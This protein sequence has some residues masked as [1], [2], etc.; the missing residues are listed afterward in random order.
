MSAP[1]QPIIVIKKKSGHAGHH[2]GAWKVAYADFVT[3]MMALFIV[4]WLM[5]ASPEVQKAVGGY[6]KDP[7]GT[8]SK[9]G[10]NVAGAGLGV[11]LDKKNIDH[12]KD[13]LEQAIKNNP[14]FEKLKD[15]VEITVTGEG[16][17]IELV[18]SEK[19][20]F[21]ESGQPLPTGTGK[22]LL[23]KLAQELGR[24]NSPVALEGHTDSQSYGA[25]GYTNWELSSDRANAARRIMQSAGL[26]PGQVSQVRGFADQQL[27]VPDKPDSPSNRRVSIILQYR[28][29]EPAK[30]EK[31]AG[32]HPKGSSDPEATKAEATKAAGAKPPSEESKRAAPDARAKGEKAPDSKPEPAKKHES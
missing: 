8:A 26:K 22:D 25:D 27:R 6:F 14:E 24:I 28:S 9:T 7:S 23:V 16:L 18:E 15:N 30:N 29:A 5:H 31:P 2:G 17:R 13:K 10:T 19:G 32:E 1:V 21:F 11:T 20:L 12:L 3:A 4:L